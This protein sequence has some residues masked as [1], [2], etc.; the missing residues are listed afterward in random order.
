MSL[1]RRA[2]SVA[3]TNY[4]VIRETLLFQTFSYSSTYSFSKSIQIG[5]LYIN[6]YKKVILSYSLGMFWPEI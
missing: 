2:R 4:T 1:K 6:N 5:F 3:K